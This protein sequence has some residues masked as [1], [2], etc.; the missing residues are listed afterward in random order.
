VAVPIIPPL[1]KTSFGELQ[2][3]QF[4]IQPGALAQPELIFLRKLKIKFV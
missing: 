1:P 4:P 3:L 2:P